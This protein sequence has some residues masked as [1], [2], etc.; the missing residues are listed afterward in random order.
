M[1]SDRK[2]I[3]ESFP[4]YCGGGAGELEFPWDDIL[5]EISLTYE[6]WDH[7]N[8]VCIDLIPRFT[9]RR[10]FLPKAAMDLREKSARAYLVRVFKIGSRGVRIFSGTMADDEESAVW[11]R[12][13][14]HARKLARVVLNARLG[15]RPGAWRDGALGF[16]EI[17]GGSHA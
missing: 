16:L 1:H 13:E 6:V 14:S 7:V 15:K 12:D 11:F 10:F 9:H 3:V 4:S 2:A 8:L 5:G 17:F